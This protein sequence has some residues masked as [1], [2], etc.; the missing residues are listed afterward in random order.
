MKEVAISQST[1]HDNPRVNTLD[2][3]GYVELARD[4][5]KKQ[6]GRDLSREGELKLLMQAGRS[7]GVVRLIRA[8]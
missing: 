2:G 8:D 7:N 6:T 4:E 3:F 5:I 1:E